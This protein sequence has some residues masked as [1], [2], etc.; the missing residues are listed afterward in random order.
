MD[1][2]IWLTYVLACAILTMTPGPSIL[3]GVVHSL[4]YGTKNTI[5]TALGDI[6]ANFI[7]MLLVAIGLGAIIS[8]SELAFQVIKWFG[9]ITLLYMGIKMI[10]SKPKK[11]ENDGRI[12]VNV[13]RKKLY[14][15]GFLVAA[16]NPKAIVFFT[17][18][19]P[20]F[21]DLNQSLFLQMSIMC[22]TMAL[23]DFFFVMFYAFSANKFLNKF[24]K[25]IANINKMGGGA[26]IGASGFL[27]L[28]SKN[29]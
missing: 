8:T 12:I 1:L 2:H 14:I 13:S 28:S 16:G 25:N 9:V 3:L 29:S 15:K 6:S 18:F 23:M 5:F 22:P 21:I 26:L 27:A 17:A 24:E 11:I 20:Q 10:K 7:Q 4:N 19:F